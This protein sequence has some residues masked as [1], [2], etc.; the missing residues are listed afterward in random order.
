M[1]TVLTYRL[2]LTAPLVATAPGGDA[3]SADTRLYVPGS[4]IRGAAVSKHR[5]S[6]GTLDA[7]DP[8]F[9]ELFLSGAVRFLHA[10]PEGSSGRRLIPAPLSLR[11]E[12]G[13]VRPEPVYDL[14]SEEHEYAYF[15]DDASSRRLE[16]VRYPFV[17]LDPPTLFHRAPE[18]S[19]TFH[20]ARHSLE[21]RKAGR[22]L[23][24]GIFTYVSL[25]PGE[26]LIG[27]VLIED[28]SRVPELEARL[29]ASL[30]L[31]R[32]KQTGYGGRARFEVIGKS[33]QTAWKEVS[34]GAARSPLVITLLSDYVEEGITG[35]A[36]IES[37]LAALG[38]AGIRVRTDASRCFVR[39]GLQAGYLQV[40]H[41]PLPQ[42]QT[43]AAGSVLVLE[44]EQPI[45][46]AA[47]ERL[48]WEGLGGRRAEG[49]G[50][51]C[52]NRHGGDILQFDTVRPL[53]LVLREV[54]TAEPAG[55]AAEAEAVL[56]LM[57]LRLLR[58]ALDRRVLAR[59]EGKVPTRPAKGSKSLLGQLRAVVRNSEGPQRVLDWI[60]A[61]APR[62][63]ET[64]TNVRVEP[65]GQ[66]LSDWI[67]AFLAPA[68][69]GADPLVWNDDHLGAQ[70]LCQGEG[71]LDEE[72]RS[73]VLLEE[74]ALVWAY[75]RKYLDAVLSRMIAQLKEAN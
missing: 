9:R 64:L 26:S 42:T 54:A 39:Y 25:L 29:P 66:R 8:T 69:E 19:V 13:S 47:I 10:Y 22:P 73:L 34:G 1:S 50:R 41:L 45:D 59:A 28:D 14:A 63:R 44:P 49:F 15:N 11:V 68:T 16:S 71:R 30:L 48:E 23:G 37:F 33:Q 4:Q 40:W 27:H 75:Q 53:D 46:P 21:E 58:S 57:R 67:A 38:A 55:R 52:F 60:D 65:G 74:P 43:L 17:A 36:S 35:Q 7:A 56:D 6:G 5:R 32:S 72:S 18:V 2:T 20:H 24:G 70:A 61:C 3:N 62:A 12:K 31:G 51:I